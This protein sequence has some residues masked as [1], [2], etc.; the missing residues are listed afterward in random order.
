M[1]IAIAILHGY[2]RFVARTHTTQHKIYVCVRSLCAA[3][4]LCVKRG[5]NHS[6]CSES[7]DQRTILI[8]RCA[9]IYYYYLMS[10]LLLC[11]FLF[12]CVF[13]TENCDFEICVS[14]ESF[15]I[16]LPVAR[17]FQAADGKQNKIAFTLAV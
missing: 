15:V 5:Q 14:V 17:L 3:A 12:F 2:V 8:I 6:L 10:L 1:M 4:A 9:A 16:V 7:Y 13:T 11:P